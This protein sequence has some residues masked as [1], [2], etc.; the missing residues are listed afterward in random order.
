MQ[1]QPAG[2]VAVRF[3]RPDLTGDPAADDQ[4]MTAVGVRFGFAVDETTMLIDPM[5]EG[6]LTTVLLALRRRKA[7]AAIVPNFDHV[8]GIDHH[9]RRVA[10]LIVAED[11]KMLER[12]QAE[13]TA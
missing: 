5:S 1:T 3:I 8:D 11:E 7:D 13:A 12:A 9:I 2:R 6:P 10:H 4:A